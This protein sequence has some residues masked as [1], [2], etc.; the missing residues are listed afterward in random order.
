MKSSSLKGRHWLGLVNAWDNQSWFDLAWSFTPSYCNS[1]VTKKYIILRKIVCRKIRLKNFQNN[2]W[3]PK[4]LQIPRLTEEKPFK[5]NELSAASARIIQ[6][7]CIISKCAAV[8]VK[9]PG[10]RS[11]TFAW[12]HYKVSLRPPVCIS[13]ARLPLNATAKS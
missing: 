8:N 7:K 13:E 1:I 10:L 3:I 4:K 2:R 11:T 6:M 9:N 12:I 5:L